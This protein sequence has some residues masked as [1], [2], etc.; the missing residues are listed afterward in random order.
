MRCR[1]RV[2]VEIES[3]NPLAMSN[4]KKLEEDFRALKGPVPEAARGN[5]LAVVS[6]VQSTDSGGSGAAPPLPKLPMAIRR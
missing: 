4:V 3:G 6:G 2:R 1:N 5:W